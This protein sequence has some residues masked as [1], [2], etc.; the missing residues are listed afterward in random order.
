[1]KRTHK[2]ESI[3]QLSIAHLDELSI[4]FLRFVTV[5]LVEPSSVI[6]LGGRQALRPTAQG[7]KVQC[8][9]TFRECKAELTYPLP[10][11]HPASHF[12]PPISPQDSD[13]GWLEGL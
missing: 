7:F 1:M 12:R 3:V 4:I 6:L 9:T 10:V 13:Y 8:S 11:A 5:L 2:D